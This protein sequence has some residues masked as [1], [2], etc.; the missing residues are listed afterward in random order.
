MLERL[1]EY[2]MLYLKSFLVFLCSL[3]F[4]SSSELPSPPTTT[5]HPAAAPY[6]PLDATPISYEGAFTKMLLVLAGLIVLIFL[7]VW[8]LRQISQGKFTGGASYR[9]IKILERKALSP[10]SSLYI[11]EIEGKRIMIAESQVEVRC[12][13]TL[14][15][16]TDAE[17][18]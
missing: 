15:E 6:D 1:Q 16:N 13:T 14:S 9:T 3:T 2:F 18:L 8:I 4:L 12:I 17:M 7:T 5:E 11:V 10:K